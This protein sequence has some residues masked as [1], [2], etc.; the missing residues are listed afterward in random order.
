[1]EIDRQTAAG[2][3]TLTVR[4]RLDAAWSGPLGESLQQTL[5]DGFHHVHLDFAGVTFL[6]SG[7]IRVLLT[8]WK[9]LR[10]VQG[11]FEIIA[12]TPDVERTLRLAGLAALLERAGEVANAATASTPS[13]SRAKPW[14]GPGFAGEIESVAPGA[15]LR[16]RFLGRAPSAAAPDLAA[17]ASSPLERASL[18]A[19]TLALGFGAFGS[20]TEG[21]PLLGE[22]LAVG[23]AAATLPADGAN[24]PD[25]LDTEG[26][27]APEALF[28]QGLVA[29][30]PFTSFARF[31]VAGQTPS[32]ALGDLLA[33]VLAAAD[34]PH[35]AFAAVVESA[36]LVG[37]HLRRAP[38][39]IGAGQAFDFPAVRDWLTFT[40]EPAFPNTV[41]LLVGVVTSGTEGPLA[42]FTRPLGANPAPRAHVHAAI[43]PYRPVRH[44]RLDLPETVAGLFESE[45]VSGVLH[46][47]ADHR[48]SGAGESRF[49]RGAF[50]FGPLDI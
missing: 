38:S 34:S 1:M 19:G 28:A 50:W 18:P 27:L 7:G 25:F 26:Q 40:A 8:H 41:A 3:A 37:A 13:T 48:P 32:S 5:R 24:Q 15:R 43:F 6:S 22:L 36:A 39:S 42:H 14:N 35:A 17:L 30:G 44:G 23:G 49:Y 31:E 33:A 29:T 4:G 20:A 11:R 12:L 45:N 21:P 10:R 9:E 47:L 46:L 16:G 2:I